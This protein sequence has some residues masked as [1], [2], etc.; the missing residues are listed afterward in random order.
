MYPEYSESGARVSLD[1]PLAPKDCH[2]L[3]TKTDPAEDSACPRLESTPAKTKQRGTSKDALDA[4]PSLPI[5]LCVGFVVV[6]RV[7][8]SSWFLLV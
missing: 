6:V 3:S 1:V 2:I 8:V 4:A 7:A 5:F